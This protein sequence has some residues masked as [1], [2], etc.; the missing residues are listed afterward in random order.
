MQLDNL[1]SMLIAE[2][3][4]AMSPQDFGNVFQD[5][6]EAC[7]KKNGRPQLA[8]QGGAGNPDFTW[9]DAEGTQWG[10]EVKT[11]ERDC[12]ITGDAMRQMLNLNQKRLIFLDKIASPYNLIIIDFAKYLEKH[13]V[14]ASRNE[15]AQESQSCKPQDW[16]QMLK[17]ESELAQNLEELLRCLNSALFCNLPEGKKRAELATRLSDAQK[18]LGWN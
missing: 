13:S 9:K 3:I 1:S 6:V 12:G 11:G 4:K 18:L 7:L 17:E 10:W 16:H 8:A 5:L 2:A 15:K 14:W